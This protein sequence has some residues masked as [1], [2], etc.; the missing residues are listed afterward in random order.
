MT[1]NL[2][3]DGGSFKDPAGRVY[4][5]LSEA[6]AERI[7]R[8]L[9]QVAAATLEKLLG[10]SFFEA[11]V[12][13]GQVVPTR[14]ARSGQAPTPSMSWQRAGVQSSNT[15]RWISS[16]GLTSGRSP[17]SR[18]RPCCNCIY[19][20]RPPRT[21]GCSRTP[22]RSMCNGPARGQCSLTYRRSFLGRLATT[23][24]GIASSALLF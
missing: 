12:A 20:R 4:R 24:G 16:L 23:G 14:T 1:A 17:C 22:R 6:G 18:V 19:W 11:L 15:I 3:S 7:I 8:G 10:E 13:G 21:G 2:R 9:D 5:V